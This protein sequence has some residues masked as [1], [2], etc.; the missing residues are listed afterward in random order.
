M[1]VTDSPT[2]SSVAQET[3]SPYERAK[4]HRQ[5]GNALLEAGDYADACTRYD[6]GLL[7][8]ARVPADEA[9]LPRTAELRLA[10]HL[11]A[12]LAHLRRGNLR[13]ASDHASGALAI[14]PYNVKALYRRG[15]ARS[16]LSEHTGREAEAKSA[17]VDF[18]KVL[19]I[20][21]SNAEARKQLKQLRDRLKREDQELA[22]K[23]K[24]TFKNIFASGKQLYDEPAHESSS[25]S[26]AYFHGLAA[27]EEDHRVMLSAQSLS[28]HYF[29]NEPVLNELT[30]D[31]RAGWCI[32]IFG[33]NA[34]GKSTL[35][36]L[37]CGNLSP[38]KG[39]IV[40]HGCVKVAPPGMAT[41]SFI[42]AAIVGFFGIVVAALIS[43]DPAVMIKS[44]AKEKNWALWTVMG[45]CI[46]AVM[47]AVKIFCNRRSA[48][49]ARHS[50]KHLSSE[51]VDKEDL[52]DSMTI[53]RL[54]GDKLPKGLKKPER[55]A[56]VIAM[57]RAAGFQMYN[58]QTGEPIGNPEEYV[59]DGLRYGAL[60]GGQRHLMYVLRCLASRPDV[61]VC[62]EALGGL[63]AFRQ[64][65][66]L[67]MLR[68][69]KEKLGTAILY[70]GCELHQHK[71]I[72][73]S[74]AVLSGGVI[75]ELGPTEMVLDF[76]KHP[77]SKDYVSNYRGL[78]GC[79]R[80]GGKLAENYSAL[81]GDK[82]LE[83]PWLPV[84]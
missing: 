70:I 33:N 21:P 13:S 3:E 44:I 17:V 46:A 9:Q 64:P 15:C 78:P 36:R 77:T 35:A 27:G 41:I 58:Q 2:Q 34:A 68:I 8:L 50:V 79:Q 57:L 83:G 7:A 38:V 18:E 22:K 43:S 4:D 60:S 84:E 82:D 74:L 16:R 62:D 51:T 29:R 11:N 6:E 49:S 31:L 1:A 48:H 73:D 52:Q 19:E 72:A 25:A 39:C 56:R 76:P 80:I 23:Q 37:L 63:D 28:F 71:V 14:D 47:L 66:V 69:M 65:R 10:L 67:H 55:R 53:E 81:A 12:S 5:Q 75:G 30:L 20:E 61:L 45:T 42:S 26:T 40:H 59:R 24:D 32:G 54:I